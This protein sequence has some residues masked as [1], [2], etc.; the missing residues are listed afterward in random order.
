MRRYF[1][2]P[3]DRRR[4]I[5][6]LALPI[7][8]GMTSQNI[9]NL[10]D[11]AMV[12]QLGAEALAGVGLVSFLSFLSVAAVTGMS[13]AVQAQAARRVGEGAHK[14]TAISLNGGLLFSLAYGLPMMVLLYFAAGPIVHAL[15]DDAGAAAEGAAY[16]EM[17]ALAIVAVG[18]NFAFRGYWSAINQTRLYMRTLLIMHVINIFLN[19]TLIFGNFGFP[20]MGTRGAG[21]GTAI[22]LCIGTCIYFF[23]AMRHSRGSGFLQRMPSAAQMRSLLKLGIPSS[24]QQI[25]FAGG[26]TVLFWIIGHIGTQEL[27]VAN[28][29]INIS[30]VAILPGMGFGIAAATLAGQALGRNAPDDAYAWGWDVCRVGAVVLIIL[31]AAMLIPSRQVLG[32]FLADPELIELGLWP[33]RLVGAGIIIDGLGLILMQA[34]LGVGASGVVMIVGVG[35][36][37]LFF[38]PLAYLLGPVLGLGLLEIWIAMNIYRGMQAAIFMAVWVRR[39]WQAIQV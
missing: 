12:G 18:M 31:G 39:R 4:E 34:L 1:A 24:I 32:I 16:F 37:W 38:L 29:L 6:T 5:L 35:L 2:V 27:A 28:V 17:R 22:S 30:L 15:L 3:S 33:L 14:E 23:L 21:L 26:F 9:L 20:E 19:Y 36:Q 25:L 10:V 7:I 13:S 8:G 11:T